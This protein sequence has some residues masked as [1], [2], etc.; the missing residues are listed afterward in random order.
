MGVLQAETGERVQR[1]PKSWVL[2]KVDCVEN[3]I[4]PQD[5]VE[6]V[7]LG[8]GLRAMTKGSVYPQ[9]TGSQSVLQ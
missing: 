9:E 2:E 5:S 7:P 3:C 8:R 4:A 6:S 1:R